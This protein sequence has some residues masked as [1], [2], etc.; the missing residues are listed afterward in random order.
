MAAEFRWNNPTA[1]WDEI[2]AHVGRTRKCLY[3]WRQS[4]AWEIAF[5]NAGNDLVEAMAPAAVA[6][7]LRAWA[8]G[9][10]A[11]AIDVLRSFGFVRNEHVEIKVEVPDEAQKRTL[12]TLLEKANA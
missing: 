12:E 11:N 8:K 4:E 6:A 2:G 5:R 7:L 10:P 9:N 3:Q 1:T